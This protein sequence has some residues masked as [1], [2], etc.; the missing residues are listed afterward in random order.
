M[1]ETTPVNRLVHE[2]NMVKRWM[3]EEMNKKHLREGRE[4]TGI[5]D[6]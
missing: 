2:L 6:E 4:L 5:R 1:S 3:S